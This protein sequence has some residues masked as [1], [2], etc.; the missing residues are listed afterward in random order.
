MNK[1]NT[2]Y[3]HIVKR[4]YLY[5]SDQIDSIASG[6]NEFIGMSNPQRPKVTINKRS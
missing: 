3:L 2:F 1:S 4:Y 6:I 5:F